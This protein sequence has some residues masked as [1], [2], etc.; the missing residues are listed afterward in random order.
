MKKRKYL[1]MLMAVFFVAALFIAG[2]T[3]ASAATSS[4]QLKKVLRN[5]T[6]ARIISFEAGDFNGD[7]KTEAFVLTGRQTF[8]DWANEYRC[9]GAVWFV[10]SKKAVRLKTSDSFGKMG[11]KYFKIFK[12]KNKKVITIQQQYPTW[13]SNYIWT[14]K[15]SS[16]VESKLSGKVSDITKTKNGWLKCEREE[17]DASV[18]EGV[19]TGRTSKP[20]YFYYKNGLKEYGGLKISKKALLKKYKN[21]KS[22][23]NGKNVTSIYYR[24]NGLINVNYKNS[25]YGCTNYY[26]ITLKISGKKVKKYDSGQGYYKKALVPSMAVYPKKF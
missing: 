3:E 4:A 15:G 16:A 14:V 13:Y 7:K 21:A 10:N 23:L 19:K 12:F 17:Y 8:D 2:K 18:Y 6:S 5:Y 22:Y 25:S 11:S 9:N 20:Y 1:S 26:Y 24:K